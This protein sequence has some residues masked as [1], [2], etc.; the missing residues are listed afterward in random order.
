MKLWFIWLL[1]PLK[2][3]GGN[4]HLESVLSENN[5]NKKT[6][7][8]ENLW[9]AGLLGTEAGSFLLWFQVPKEPTVPTLSVLCGSQLSGKE[10]PP[11]WQCLLWDSLFSCLFSLKFIVFLLVG[12][13][14]HCCSCF[15]PDGARGLLS[16]PGA[17]AS[18]AGGFSCCRENSI[19][20]STFSSFGSQDLE[21]RLNSCGKRVYVSHVM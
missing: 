10:Q 18:H 17:H 20:C 7:L 3:G 9:M 6:Q 11:R 19:E 16:S 4:S 21:H 2:N 5:N 1:R 13:G 14:L 15:S 12:L 8:K